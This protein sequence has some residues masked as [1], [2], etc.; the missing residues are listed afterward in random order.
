MRMTERINTERLAM[1]VA[2]LPRA[3]RAA[4]LAAVRRERIIAGAYV[5]ADGMCPLLGG[6]RYGVRESGEGFAEAWDRFCG[7]R[8][9]RPRDATAP[10]RAVLIGLLENSLFHRHMEAPRQTFRPSS[11]VR[12]LAAA[13]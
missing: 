12:A 8:R 2:R 3:L 10:E 11:E 9:G 7:V 6:H 13:L 4:M 1:A 5:D